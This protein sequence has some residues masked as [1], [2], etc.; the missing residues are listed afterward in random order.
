MGKEIA[1][2][3]AAT[4]AT[5]IIVGRECGLLWEAARDIEASAHVATVRALAGDLSSLA[6]VRRLAAEIAGSH[7]RID[8]LVN[9]AGAHFRRRHESVDGLEATWAVN[10]VGPYLLTELL[11]ERILA[12]P[13]GRIVNVASDAM[14]RTL[15]FADL[16]ANVPFRSWRA[17]GE[18]KL[19]LVMYSYALADRLRATGVTVNAFH[20]GLMATSVAAQAAP[21]W[22]PAWLL[23]LVKLFLQAPSAGAATALRLAT[24]P[25]LAAVTGKYFRNGREG[26]ST[27]V[28]YDPLRQRRLV[29]TAGRLTSQGAGQR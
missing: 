9:N 17:Y 11:L 1:R 10:F 27:P 22:M 8:I 12:A 29:E 28:S 19:A 6:D 7:P 26:L 3:L 21:E 14:S 4:G 20:P 5:V 18:A 24:S 2:G 13:N 15:T 23:G 25:E 16:Q